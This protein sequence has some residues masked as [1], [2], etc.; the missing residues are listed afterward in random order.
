MVFRYNDNVNRKCFKYQRIAHELITETNK[1]ARSGVFFLG[2]QDAH[3]YFVEALRRLI[4]FSGFKN[5]IT[6]F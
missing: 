4:F 2:A 5:I 6:Q 3:G 1:L